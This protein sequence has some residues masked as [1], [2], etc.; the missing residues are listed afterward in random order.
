MEERVR[1]LEI[2]LK[3]VTK[4]RDDLSRDVESLCLHGDGYVSFSS[5]SV[6]SER[7]ALAEKQLTM[8]QSQVCLGS[9]RQPVQ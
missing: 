9:Q 7:I 1:Q 8:T 4:E 3:R 6:L 2:T 5:S